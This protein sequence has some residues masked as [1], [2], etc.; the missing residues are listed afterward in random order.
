M[1]KIQKYRDTVLILGNDKWRDKDFLDMSVEQMTD[2]DVW[3]IG[4][5]LYVDMFGQKENYRN[6]KEY[7][8]DYIFE[9]HTLETRSN[10]YIKFLEF[11]SRDASIVMQE[12]FK[13]FNA[14]K[15]PLDEIINKFNTR[16]FMCTFAYMFALAIFCG[17]KKIKIMGV[18]MTFLDDYVQKYNCDFWLGMALGRGLNIELSAYCD[19]LKMPKMY[20]YEADNSVAV[21]VYEC[22]KAKYNAILKTLSMV[23]S[24]IL[25]DELTDLF[26]SL[27]IDKDVFMREIYYRHGLPENGSFNI[28]GQ[29]NA[30][31]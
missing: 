16:Y 15:F 6:I 1:N 7:A 5:G 31:Y 17:Y 2:Y 11:I 25:R 29:S 14:I 18:N 10:E 19:L 23:N 12:S 20:G 22:V 27:F 8:F 9:L 3:V 28:E 13:E 30:N 26:R 4:G 24:K 21:H